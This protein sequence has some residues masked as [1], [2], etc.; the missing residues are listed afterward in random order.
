MNSKQKGSWAGI[1]QVRNGTSEPAGKHWSAVQ[2][3]ALDLREY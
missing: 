1:G 2:D 3:F